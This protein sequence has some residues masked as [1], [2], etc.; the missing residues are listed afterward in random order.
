M[1]SRKEGQK[2]EKAENLSP[3]EN[4]YN[5]PFSYLAAVVRGKIK[6]EADDLSSLENNLVVVEILDAAKESAKTG[7]RIYLK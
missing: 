3:R 5:D 7:K 6:V 4:P 2:K 1:L